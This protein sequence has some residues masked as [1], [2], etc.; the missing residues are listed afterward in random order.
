MLGVEP[1]QI[2]EAYEQLLA[3]VKANVPTAKLEGALAVEM[4]PKG[5]LELIVGAKHVPGLG[6]MVMVGLG[7]IYVEVFKDINFGYAPI[8]Q[9][10]AEQM[11][12]KLQVYP[13]LKGTRGQSGYDVPALLE[14]LGRISCLVASHPEIKEL[15]INPLLVLPAGQGAKVLDARIMG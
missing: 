7:G 6:T 12:E 5:G 2:P 4:A 15:D 1:V 11:V 3:R 14:V 13:I 10:F 8:S 9:E